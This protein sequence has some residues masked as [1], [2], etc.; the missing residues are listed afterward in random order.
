MRYVVVLVAATALCALAPSA[1][2]EEG[3][4]PDPRLDRVDHAKPKALASLAPELGL[5]KRSM[6]I[7]RQLAAKK[8][9]ATETLAQIVRWVDRNLKVDSVMAGRWRSID[10]IIQ[11]GTIGGAADRAVVVGALARAAGIPTTW[12]KTL[13]ADWLIAARSGS[14]QKDTSTGHVFLEVHLGGK[15]RLYDPAAARLYETY[16]PSARRLPGGQLAFDK[17]GDPYSLVL[18]NRREL[19]DKQVRRYVAALELARIPWAKPRDL[20]ARWRV[21]IVGKGD[22][23]SYVRATAKAFGYRVERSF[24]K[25]WG[26]ELAAARGKTLIVT[27][28]RGAPV[29]PRKYWAAY[30]P[31]GY[32]GMSEAER[33]PS[34]GW[35]SHRLE[36]GTRVI[37][38]T[39]TGY[40]PI[41]LAVSDALDE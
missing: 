5:G 4:A 36:D 27:S 35:M 39:A 34:D 33:S 1:T 30:L 21:Y 9:E 32:E 17:G 29:L 7:V 15:W 22:A 14:A 19:W 16:E 24:N 18:P 38:V 12:V 11:D 23:A 10:Q 20:L 37:L 31:K 3:P 26:R 41:E 28:G 6:G 13:P 2:C 40:G 25:D 8:G